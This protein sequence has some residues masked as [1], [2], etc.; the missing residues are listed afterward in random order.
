MKM[1]ARNRNPNPEKLAMPGGAGVCPAVIQVLET[2]PEKVFPRVQRKEETDHYSRMPRRKDCLLS[3]A[4]GKGL[5]FT[6]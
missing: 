2:I 4:G 5:Y 6:P 1:N 3:G